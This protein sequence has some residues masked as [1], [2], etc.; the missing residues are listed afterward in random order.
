[1]QLSRVSRGRINMIEAL[2]KKL[3]RGEC[4]G[5]ATAIGEDYKILEQKRVIKLT[6]YGGGMYYMRLLKKGVG[7]IALKI[8]N[9]GD[10]SDMS[11]TQLPSATLTHYVGPET[12]RELV[13]RH[14]VESSRK[15]TQEIL[16]A[17]R[18]GGSH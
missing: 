5:P 9:D 13:R 16:R 6:P 14:Q 18:T 8:I 15:E 11:A 1:M 17:L 10:A 12:K 4:V 7:E 2:L 3:I